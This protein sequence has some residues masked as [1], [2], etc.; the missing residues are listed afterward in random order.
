MRAHIIVSLCVVAVL[1]AVTF[2]CLIPT[3]PAEAVSPSQTICY[4]PQAGS[5]WINKGTAG[6]A[7][8][9]YV[10]SPGLFRIKSNGHPYWGDTGRN[11]FV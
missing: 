7:Y 3:P 5:T 1:V 8:N 6:G 2:V 9:A 10:S 11:D 4:V